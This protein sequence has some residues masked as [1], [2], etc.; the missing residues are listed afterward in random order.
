MSI[1]N[2]KELGIFLKKKRASL[3]IQN[4]NIISNRKRRVRGLRREE[5][6]ELAHISTDWYTKL[7][8]G[9]TVSPSV[10]VLLSLS[11]VLELNKGEREYLFALAGHSLPVTS[12]QKQQ[13]TPQLQ[14]FLNSQN[15]NPAYI[16]D[17]YWNFIGWNTATLA[18]FGNY[19]SM[20]TRAKNSIWRMFTD[21]FMQKLL[22]DWEGH[23]KLRVSQ[24]RVVYS[25]TGTDPFLSELVTQLCQKSRDFNALWHDLDI[26]GTPEGDKL[27]HHP[28]VGDLRLSHLS[29]STTELPNAI[30]T[31]NVANDAETSEKLKQLILKQ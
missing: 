6:A 5:V 17:K 2:Y 18:V 16:T 31:V 8:Q 29:F 10:S 30:I 1:D 20:N 4:F 15:P 22:D 14:N 13:I 25:R 19:V 21:P 7:E 28:Q 3:N 26:I 23:A 11:N 9:R 12:N 24:L 27:L